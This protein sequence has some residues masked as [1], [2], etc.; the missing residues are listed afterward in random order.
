[1]SINYEEKKTP[2]KFEQKCMKYFNLYGRNL[3]YLSLETRKESHAG[4]CHW[5]LFSK[6]RRKITAKYICSTL[7][8]KKWVL[9]QWFQGAY[10][11]KMWGVS[12]SHVY[13]FNSI[14]QY[15]PQH[16]LLAWQND[17]QLSAEASPWVPNKAH[18]F[19]T[20]TNSCLSS[21]PYSRKQ[22]FCFHTNQ[23]CL[24]LTCWPNHLQE[25]QTKLCLVW[26]VKP[27]AL[28]SVLLSV[29]AS[30]MWT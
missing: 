19:S 13:S 24:H 20:G 23:T 26:L 14:A 12:L 15:L 3:K 29:S 1:M 8:G 2:Y 10:G 21:C 25:S 7:S 5:C 9:H 27:L 30:L 16:S 6:V 22:Q 11:R 18:G 4:R 17:L 28:G